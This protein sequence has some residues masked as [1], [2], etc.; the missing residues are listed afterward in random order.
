MEAQT[1]KFKPSDIYVMVNN[2][3]IQDN[4][5]IEVF[6]YTGKHYTYHINKLESKT[7][8]PAEVIAAVNRVYG[9][10]LMQQGRK[11]PLPKARQMFYFVFREVVR[12]NLSLANTG[13]M[14]NGQDHSTVLHH[15]RE[16]YGGLD[17]TDREVIYYLKS[18]CKILGFEFVVR[19]R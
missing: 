11:Q 17:I 13:E 5:T 9:V 12:T 6:G 16:V 14:I 7:H 4:K 18:V 8:Y 10:D 19:K 2:R 3:Q 1:I 15:I